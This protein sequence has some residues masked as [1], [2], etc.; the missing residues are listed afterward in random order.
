MIDMESNITTVPEEAFYLFEIIITRAI[1]QG[2]A[3]NITTIL[4]VV[5]GLVEQ[6]L[7][8]FILS[9]IRG[10]KT[11][12]APAGNLS[13]PKDQFCMVV[14]TNDISVQLND[15]DDFVDLY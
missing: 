9:L 12:P 1:S 14:L 10:R 3:R 13:L 7:H 4:A 5:K 8:A 2:N 11:L 6:Y 15:L